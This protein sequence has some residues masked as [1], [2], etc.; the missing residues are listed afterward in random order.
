ML[1]HKHGYDGQIRNQHISLQSLGG[2]PRKPAR[3]Q[4][5]LGEPLIPIN[6]M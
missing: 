4:M 2:K 1:T 5:D 3:K 6:S